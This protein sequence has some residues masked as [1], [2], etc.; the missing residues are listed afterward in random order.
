MFDGRKRRIY[1]YWK[2]TG[3]PRDGSEVEPIVVLSS[4][5]VTGPLNRM[6]VFLPPFALG[7]QT[8]GSEPVKQVNSLVLKLAAA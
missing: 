8:K 5:T 6:C 4:T 3:R 7:F 1:S 2:A